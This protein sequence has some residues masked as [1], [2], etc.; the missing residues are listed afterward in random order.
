MQ[1]ID[2]HFFIQNHNVLDLCQQY[3]AP[4]YV[5]DLAIIEQQYH[6]LLSAFGNTQV[7]IKYACKALSNQNILRFMHRLGAGLDTVSIYEV[8]KGLLAGFAPSDAH[9]AAH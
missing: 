6:R 9:H 2:N 1:R 7:R 8:Q 5:Y 3:G 4:L